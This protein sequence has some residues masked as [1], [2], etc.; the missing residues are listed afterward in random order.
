[1]TGNGGNSGPGPAPPLYKLFWWSV[2]PL[3]TVMQ[4]ASLY[5]EHR[6]PADL[7]SEETSPGAAIKLWPRPCRVT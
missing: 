1:M 6:P 4:A 2:V 3:L 7:H 5:A